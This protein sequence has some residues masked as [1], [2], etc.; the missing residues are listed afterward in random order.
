MTASI[1]RVQRPV[2]V[3][4]ALRRYPRGLPAALALISEAPKGDIDAPLSALIGPCDHGQVMITATVPISIE[5]QERLE[6]RLTATERRV[7]WKALYGADGGTA[8]MLSEVEG[9]SRR[10]HEPLP[11]SERKP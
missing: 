11:I 8:L 5:H 9:G 3:K 6:R 1:I 7:P 4:V 2:G 10:R